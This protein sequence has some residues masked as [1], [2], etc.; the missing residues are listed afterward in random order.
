[1]MTVVLVVGMSCTSDTSAFMMMVL[2][3]HGSRTFASE[4]VSTG[5]FA[6]FVGRF[7]IMMRENTGRRDG[8]ASGRHLSVSISL[9]Q[10]HR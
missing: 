8:V 10:Q 4:L 6:T 1:M 3:V 7:A 9:R 2:M 5:I